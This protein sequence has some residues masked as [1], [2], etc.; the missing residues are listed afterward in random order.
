MSRTESDQFEFQKQREPVS[1]C[2][3]HTILTYR[4]WHEFERVRGGPDIIDFD[5]ST[6]EGSASFNSR[7]EVLFELSKLYDQ[8]D[9]TTEEEEFLR[10]RVHGSISY[11]RV[12]MGQQI[13]FAEYLKDTLGLAPVPFSNEEVESARNAVIRYLAP[14]GLTL[15]VEDRELF[16]SKLLIHDANE[17]RNGIV[18]SQELWLQRL[19]STGIPVPKQLPFSVQFAEVDAYWNNWI[20][21]SAQKGITLIINLHA[22]KR[23]DKGRPLVLCLHEICGH[24][25]QM[26]IWRELIAE[27][28]LNQACGLTTV[29][30]PEVFVS[31]G[32][33]QTVPELLSDE[34]RFTPEFHLSRALQYHTLVIL[35]NAHLML[36]ENIPVESILDYT[37]T[38]L[39]LADPDA[40]EYEIRDRGTNPLFRSYLLSYAIGEQTIRRL[41]QGMSLSQKRD[42]FL[43]MYTRPLTPA[44][45]LQVADAVTL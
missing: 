34:W 43:E 22:R 18:G 4:G 12:L 32:L 30:S 28:K 26:S 37:I 27:G 41:V 14:F 39:P 19:R 17:I 21:G 1:Q 38:H 40:L 31:E 42:F 5:L 25:V 11:L 8:L 3:A 36:Y 45:L 33:G 2:T 16:E 35:H 7:R 15:R 13:P 29:H 6:F 44:Q 20:S 24:A 9:G 10:A 23:Y